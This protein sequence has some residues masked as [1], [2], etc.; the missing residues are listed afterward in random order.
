MPRFGFAYQ[1]TDRFVVRGGYGAT[2]FYE[3]NSSNQR[4]TSITPFIQAVN[5]NVVTPT[6]G[7]PG[8]PRTAEQGFAGGTVAF[9][10]TFNVY[11][12]DIQP[13]YIQE[14]NL[15][16]EYAVTNSMSL[17]VGYL[18]EQGQHI[19][20]YGNLNQYLVNG[21]PTSAPYYKNKYLG[22]NAIDPSVSIGS[23]SLLIT[24]SRAA[25][26]YQALQAILRKRFS[27]GTGVHV[28]LY[29]WQS[30]DQ[31]LRQLSP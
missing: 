9:G 10:G 4:L 19:E 24:E 22:I 18:G 23:N 1:A 15:T 29:L 28:E 5:V 13:A 25:M 27:H 7:N 26:N 8:V 3:G 31:Q 11:P 16:T 6:P 12:K 20:D 21:D 14:W 17:Q 2:S 30:A